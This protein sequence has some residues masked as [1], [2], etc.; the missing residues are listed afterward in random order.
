MSGLSHEEVK[1]LVGAYVL[2][3][4]PEGEAQLVRAHILSCDECLAEADSYMAPAGSLALAVEPVDPPAGFAD[5]VMAAALGTAEAEGPRPLDRDEGAKVVRG[6]WT[7]A[8]RNLAVAATIAALLVASV[9]VFG[10]IR[11][12]RELDETQAALT[13]LLHSDEGMA[14]QGSGGAVAR[15]V[16][17]FR[18]ATMIATG[19]DEAPARHVYQVWLMKDGTPV[20]AGLFDGSQDVS[21]IE[22]EA[23]LSRFEAAAITIEP[24]G[25]SAG[26]TTEPIL[27]S[28]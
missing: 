6:P 2:G 21:I 27:T 19:F 14:L 17:T 20:S 3:A 26:P 15:I 23:E 7:G 13:A 1:D 11:A 28:T 10:A 4:V 24:D 18:G 9:S 25:G 12:T 22:M 16:P 8:W 5:R